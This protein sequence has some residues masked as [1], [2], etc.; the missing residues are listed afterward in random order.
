MREI[1]FRAKRKDD[2]VWVFGCYTFSLK[3]DRHLIWIQSDDISANW[4][5]FPFTVDSKSVGQY[6]GLKDK[7]GKEIYEGDIV[8]F[9]Y[10][11][12][13]S[14]NGKYLGVIEFGNPN[15]QATWGW[16]IK[17][18]ERQPT[19][20]KDILYWIEDIYTKCEVIGNI[21]ENAE[22]LKGE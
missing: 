13:E 7:N 20:S 1:K 14:K 11:L 21:H 4:H 9:D 10:K 22:L 3:D 16:A 6:T 19:T 2:G 17:F 18:V 8:A 12:D 15:G 5:T